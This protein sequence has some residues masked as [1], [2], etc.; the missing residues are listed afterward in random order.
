LTDTGGRDTVFWLVA[1]EGP[2]RN[3]DTSK[4][5]QN[6]L[7]RPAFPLT[8]FISAFIDSNISKE[9]GEIFGC[10]AHSL[11]NNQSSFGD[12]HEYAE[13]EILEHTGF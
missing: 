7:P 5:S 8:F 9:I 10:Y 6:V 13:I 2:G 11:P 4:A 3:Q 1:G 12:G